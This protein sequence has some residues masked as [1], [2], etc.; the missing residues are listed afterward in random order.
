M[1]RS[2]TYSHS[3][4]PQNFED[5]LFCIP[6]Y[7]LFPTLYQ[8]L[9]EGHCWL[10]CNFIIDVLSWNISFTFFG[11]VHNLR[12]HFS[13]VGR[14]GSSNQHK[15]ND[16]C[17]CLTNGISLTTVLSGIGDKHFFQGWDLIQSSSNALRPFLRPIPH[18]LL[19]VPR[20][21]TGAELLLRPKPT[22]GRPQ[23]KLWGPGN[24]YNYE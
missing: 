14:G 15:S 18:Q 4:I 21:T 20:Y 1:L 16:L 8:E 24:K 10:D 22:N 17:L 3:Q 2:T 9:D 11:N 6:I 12:L 13:N 19:N 5:W 23:K 7:Y